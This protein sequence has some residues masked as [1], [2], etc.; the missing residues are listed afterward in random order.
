MEIAARVTG[1][2]IH[3]H[4]QSNIQLTCLRIICFRD[5]NP[6]YGGSGAVLATVSKSIQRTVQV[7][8]AEV[9]LEE[10]DINGELSM[11]HLFNG[12]FDDMPRYVPSEARNFILSCCYPCPQ[13]RWSAR[14][15]REH[16]Y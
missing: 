10:L 9:E 16:A 1:G 7:L 5:E 13:Q 2:N 15:A 3:T 6:L 14:M 4:N 8:G 12:D 11:L